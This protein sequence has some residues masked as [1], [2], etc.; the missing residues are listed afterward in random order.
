MNI[1]PSSAT[2]AFRDAPDWTLL[3]GETGADDRIRA[4]AAVFS[5]NHC[6]SSSAVIA[7]C[8]GNGQDGPQVRRDRAIA[9]SHR[10]DA[11]SMRWRKR[12]KRSALGRSMAKIVVV[13]VMLAACYWLTRSSW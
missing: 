5:T 8:I 10:F 2:A 4:Q 6:A 7:R 12:G 9:A 13:G 1:A 11:R 3:P